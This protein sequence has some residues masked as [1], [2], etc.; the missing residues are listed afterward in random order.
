M[1]GIL[2]AGGAG[3]RLHPT[4]RGVSKQLLPLYDKPMVYYPLTTLLWTGAKEILIITTPEDQAAFQRLLGDGSWAGIKLVWAVQ[5]EPKGIS[6]ALLIGRDFLAGEPCALA[7]GDNIFYGQGL[8]ETLQRVS[9]QAVEGATVFTYQVSDPERY[10]VMEFDEKGGPKSILEKPVKAPSPWAVTGLY[11][12]DGS[13]C[14][15]AARLKPSARGE[16]EITDLNLDYLKSGQ[17]RVEK[18]SRGIAWLDT[19]T[20]DAMLQ[21]SL[22]IQAIETRQ[23]LK[24]CCPE[25]VA[26]R[27]GLIGEKEIRQQA[28]VLGKSAYGRYLNSLLEKI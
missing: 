22:F 23:G 2:L 5:P 10:G 26:F 7:L 17:L 21:A 19:G 13:A 3:T 11:M 6:Q 14:E 18:L 4:T 9:R 12:Y 1:K 25:E 20:P 27:L 16:L 24:V 28:Q 15:R 8:P